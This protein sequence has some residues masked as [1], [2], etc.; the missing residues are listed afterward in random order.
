MFSLL[1]HLRAVYY[2]CKI[3]RVLFKKWATP[4]QITF[5]AGADYYSI[6]EYCFLTHILVET[7]TRGYQK[8][9]SI[10]IFPR[11]FLPFH[12]TELVLK[13]F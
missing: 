2:L 9:Q 5:T 13:L 7:N 10:I 4:F 8:S 1:A 6:A 3:L 11:S 12:H